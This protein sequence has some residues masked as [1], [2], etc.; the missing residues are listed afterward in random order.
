MLKYPK[1][2]LSRHHG[3]EAVNTSKWGQLPVIGPLFRMFCD[4]RRR[5]EY[6]SHILFPMEHEL[7][8]SVVARPPANLTA[9]SQRERDIIQLLSYAIK[10]EKRLASAPPVYL[11]DQLE[12]LLWGVDDLTPLQFKLLFQRHFQV[13]LDPETMWKC[14]SSPGAVVSDL[15]LY[16]DTAL[17][18]TQSS[19]GLSR[20]RIECLGD[21][22]TRG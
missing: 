12:L 8:N 21:E 22:I 9:L 2:W 13:A 10:T 4:W 7:I 6:K 19:A 20:H 11:D 15:I 17:K 18:S 14:L 5:I 1:N 16:C 3:D